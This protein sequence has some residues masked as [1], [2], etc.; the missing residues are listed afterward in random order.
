MAVENTG[1]SVSGSKL[2]L[3]LNR[4]CAQHKWLRILVCPIYCNWATCA[5]NWKTKENLVK[6]SIP[7]AK[8]QRI[9]NSRHIFE[10]IEN[11]KIIEPSIH[12]P[13]RCSR[14]CRSRIYLEE[15]LA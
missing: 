11:R 2:A 7:G 12:L 9:K 13:Y 1:I 8:L 3:P 14:Y 5:C 6:N 10:Y 4:K 15:K